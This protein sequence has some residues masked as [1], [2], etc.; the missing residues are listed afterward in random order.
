M[1]DPAPVTRAI[2]PADG[3][4]C[5]I[6]L[7]PRRV[8]DLYGEIRRTRGQPAAVGAEGEALDRTADAEHG[9]LDAGGRVAQVNGAVHMGG[10]EQL[11]R[12]IQGETIAGVAGTGPGGALLPRGRVPQADAVGTHGG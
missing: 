9:V 6:E 2:F 12:R 5:P 10:G 3:M 11:P 7:V 1:P 8:P 4:A